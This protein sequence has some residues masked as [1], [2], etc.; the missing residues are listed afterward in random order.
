MLGFLLILLG[1]LICG[2][3]YAQERSEAG[4]LRIGVYISPP[5]VD[6]VGETAYTGMAIDL[7]TQIAQ[8]LGVTFE[9]EEYPTFRDLLRATAD[10]TLDAAITNLT[11]T[12]DRAEIVSFTQ[13]W[14]DAGLRLMVPEEGGANGWDVIS[15]LGDAGHLRAYAWLA[16][17]ILLA[18]L[19]L[20]VFDRKFDPDFPKRWR[21]GLADSFHHVMSIATSGK[22]ARKNLFGWIGRIWQALWLVVGVA[23]IAYV[24]SSV[25]SVMTTVSLTRGINSLSDMSD[26]T[27]A[28]FTG[29]VAEDYVR[30]LGLP[31]R[32]YDNIALSVAALDAGE[33]DAI[34]GDAPILEHYALNNPQDQLAV[35][36]TIFHPDKYGFA[37][38]L[39]SELTRAVT[40]EILAAQESGALE[41]LKQRYF[42]SGQ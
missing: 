25:T 39:G 21:D 19:G 33:V 15:G 28:V 5:F 37:F 7:W 40:L 36:G 34:V 41:A 9:Y 17:V 14:Y 8:R 23:V 18:T 13:P 6:T 38:P 32:A 2:S 26:K 16:I 24:T 35:V 1:L 4:P 42:G 27:A 31:A 11:I 20:T 30:E 29:S 3:T 10:G 22:T 12:R